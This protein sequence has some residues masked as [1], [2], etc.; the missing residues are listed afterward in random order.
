MLAPMMGAVL[1]TLACAS[2]QAQAI[3]RYAELRRGIV[4]AYATL[5]GAAST[6]KGL[7]VFT[8]STARA[9]GLIV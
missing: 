8:L 3:D 9:A 6:A 1:A 7:P 5:S 2:V 4:G